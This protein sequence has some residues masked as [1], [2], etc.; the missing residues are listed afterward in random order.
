MNVAPG[1]AALN[2][3]SIHD[4]ARDATRNPLA[5]SSAA[6]LVRRTPPFLPHGL[7]MHLDRHTFA[8]ERAI[9]ESGRWGS[10]PRPSAWETGPDPHG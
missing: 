3:R 1:R 5:S 6:Q 8:A 9:H 4:R 2:Q 7:N 10:N